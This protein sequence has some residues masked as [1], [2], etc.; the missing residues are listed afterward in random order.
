MADN[1]T[2]TSVGY[3]N[4]GRVGRIEILEKGEPI[5]GMNLE[6]LD[7][8][9]QTNDM[10][11][12]NVVAVPNRATVQILG[13]SRASVDNLCQFCDI[14][15]FRLRQITVRISAGYATD[16]NGIQELMNMP[17]VRAIPSMPPENWVTLEAWMGNLVE[18]VVSLEVETK[19][20]SGREKTITAYDVISQ[21]GEKFKV[22]FIWRGK[23][24]AASEESKVAFFGVNGGLEQ[25]ISEIRIKFG[26]LRLVQ[27]PSV[28]SEGTNVY[29]VH[30]NPKSKRDKE[31]KW[32]WEEPASASMN[33]WEVNKDKGMIG[34]PSYEGGS[35]ESKVVNVRTLLNPSY[36][37]NDT[38]VL[39]SDICKGLSDTY[40]IWT[41]KH[42]GHLR[43]NEWYSDLRCYKGAKP[44]E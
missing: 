25:A 6:G 13:L 39:K 26:F 24:Q 18:K 3:A 10:F 15:T 38:V 1:S 42:T 20:E 14:P 5:S 4:F 7:F 21:V 8:K 36:R 30:L 43:G 35:T 40:K 23:A 31:G 11:M 17:V 37:H 9:F 32:T 34:L 12:A 22:S 44:K 19:D 16:S 33:V 27:L 29:E 2:I 28:S 41:V